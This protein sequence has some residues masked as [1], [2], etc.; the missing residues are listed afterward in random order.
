MTSSAVSSRYANALVDVV[1]GARSEADPQQTAVQLREFEA[2]VR[3]SAELRN[4]LASPAVPVSRK[5]AVVSRL[6]ERIG[7]SKISRN[8]L[9]VLLDHR[10]L[11]A[12]ADIVDQFEIPNVKISTLSRGKRAAFACTL[13]LAARAPVTMFDEAHL[14]MDAP[15]RYAFYDEILSDY[16]THPRTVILSTHHI[17]EVASLFGRVAILD[18]GRV[19]VDSETDAL[20][21]RGVEV[22][23]PAGPTASSRTATMV[24]PKCSTGT[25]PQGIVHFP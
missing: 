7:F 25:C 2:L 15:T 23:G 4:V 1:T 6:G 21:A 18:H 19:L 12:L 20:R 13:G 8:F 11:D 3:D 17:D 24:W 10:R 16:L 14:G 22:V 9:F 5:R